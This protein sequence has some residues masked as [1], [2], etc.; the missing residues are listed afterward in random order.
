MKF[1]NFKIVLDSFREYSDKL[2]DA[3]KVGLD[4][5]DFFDNIHTGTWT[6]LKEIYTEEGTDWISW[7]LYEKNGDEDMKAWDKDKNEICYDDKSLWEMLENEYKLSPSCTEIEDLKNE[8]AK[9]QEII[10]ILNSKSETFYEL[11][12]QSLKNKNTLTDSK[13]DFSKMILDAEDYKTLLKKVV[14]M[15]VENP[16]L[17]QGQAFFN[18]LLD[19][20]PDIAE[21]IRGTEYDCF[22][23]DDKVYDVLKILLGV[24]I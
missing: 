8:L 21:T 1:E 14:V 4:F 3:L 9:L 16:S 11:Y 13:M 2:D 10:S 15:Q 23:N 12:V 6:L 7:Y 5:L 19:L 22:Y 17:R 20:H 24:R 18:S